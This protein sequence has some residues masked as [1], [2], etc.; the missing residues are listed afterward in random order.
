[1]LVEGEKRKVPG[2]GG[3]VILREDGCL[4]DIAPT[5]LEILELPQPPEMTGRSLIV[6]APYETRLNRTPVS[7]KI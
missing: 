5:I 7:L 1:I 2:H 6:S 3:N 4:A